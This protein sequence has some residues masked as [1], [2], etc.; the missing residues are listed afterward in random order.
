M[1]K[2]TPNR[3]NSL[4]KIYYLLASKCPFH[5]F[6]IKQSQ[7][8]T[9]IF[10]TMKLSPIIA[11]ASF[12]FLSVEGQTACTTKINTA[13]ACVKRCGDTG[14]LN[15]DSNGIPYGNMLLE[16]IDQESTFNTSQ[17]LETCCGMASYTDMDCTSSMQE[18]DECLDTELADVRT[19]A[20]DYLTCIYD[21]RDDGQCA[22]ANFCVNILTGGHGTGM[23][24]DFSVGSG[25]NLSSLATNALSCDDMDV[26]GANACEQVSGCCEPCADKIAGVVNTVINDI[27]L[28]SYNDVLADCGDKKCSE[29]TPTRQL[30]DASMPGVISVTT[31]HT[32]D[33]AKLMEGCDNGLTTDI[34]LH[35]QTHAVD[36]YFECLYKKTGKIMAETENATAAP[37]STSGASSIILSTSMVVSTIASITLAIAA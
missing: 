1:I 5:N 4:Q 37:E 30:E 22:F 8:V 16:C 6:A 10:L 11:F 14:S 9:I 18:A 28:P 27:L 36:N 23:P 24:N 7:N 17:Q 12:N 13:Q 25:S 31:D 15:T 33:V 35:N 32:D 26:F 20:V 21:A 19:S 34:V 2:F 3:H 29:Y